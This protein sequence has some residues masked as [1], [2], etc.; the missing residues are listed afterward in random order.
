MTKL[1]ITE[2]TDMGPVYCVIGLVREGSAIYSLRPLPPRSNGWVSFPFQRGDILECSLVKLPCARPHTEDRV[3]TREW[4]KVG[5]ICHSEVVKYLHRAEVGDSLGDLFGCVVK[6][7]LKGSGMYSQ[8]G[9]GMRSICGC[10]TVNLA[11]ENV[12]GELRASL[13]LRSGE[14]LRD[15]PVVDRDWIDFVK[16]ER[17]VGRARNF[18]KSLE[19]FLAP[20]FSK[21]FLIARTTLFVL[22]S[23]AHL[24][25]DAGSCWTL[26]FLCR[27]LPGWRNSK[28]E[29]AASFGSIRKS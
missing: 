2:I 14:T 22:A 5:E 23:R 6:E 11:L 29:G 26:C 25:G 13:V 28:K 4:K 15:L 12:G 8:P 16:R 1:L 17:N 3:S 10:V 9:A 20:I 24:R 18:N 27:R 21:R 19:N 7:N